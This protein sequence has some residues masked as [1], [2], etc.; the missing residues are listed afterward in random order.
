MA[1][2]CR[3]ARTQS[4]HVTSDS[5][6][7]LFETDVGES[8]DPAGILIVDDHRENIRA[9]EA[10]LEPLGQPLISVESG[11]EALRALL[12]HDVAVILLDVRM[13]GMDGVETARFIRSRP[14][15]R[16][17]PII[18]LTAMASDAEQIEL[19]YAA[20]AIDYV[21]KPFEPS[22]LRAKVMAF[23][24]L[25]RE[26]AQR[27]RQAR[28]LAR[29]EA[30]AQAV[31]TLQS[32]SDVALAH[33]ELAPLAEE[34]LDRACVLFQARGARLLIGQ[35]SDDRLQRLSDRGP[36]W[37]DEDPTLEPAVRELLAAG[38]AALLTPDDHGWSGLAARGARQLV[39]IPLRDPD[40]ADSLG[41]LLLSSDLESAFDGGDLSLL[42]LAGERIAAAVIRAQRFEYQRE[43]VETLQRS[44]LPAELPQHPRVELAAR[45]LPEGSGNR[46]GGDWYDALNL[47]D[48]KVAL[49]IGDVT[50]HGVWAASR[51]GELR[52]ALRAYAVE[53]HSP[54]RALTELDRFVHSTFGAGMAATVLFAILDLGAR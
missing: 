44:L 54:A 20:G 46:V 4:E 37:A 17:I 49:M 15:T 16:H 27:M 42:E 53:G 52:N 23:V 7:A 24:T 34:L 9:L 28:A 2:R 51:M 50:G 31:R 43:L 13:T 30:A 19:A 45:Y 22:I 38:S 25:R 11:E 39:A 29:A 36:G 5:R 35:T 26:R 40:Q 12:Y 18:F 1:Q 47:A 33:L 21:T 41:L 10:V 32:L 8:L 6:Q 14:T 3:A 48:Q